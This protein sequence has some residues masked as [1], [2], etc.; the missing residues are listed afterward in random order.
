[1][2]KVLNLCVGHA[3]TKLPL[4]QSRDDPGNLAATP[5][6]G[7]FVVNINLALLACEP[8]DRSAREIYLSDN[9]RDTAV[10]PAFLEV[11]HQV[12]KALHGI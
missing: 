9:S 10:E 7:P 6:P 2:H 4:H 12:L 1:L 3:Q 8:K 11:G 5:K